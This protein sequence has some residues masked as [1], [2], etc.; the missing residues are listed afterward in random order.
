MLTAE[1]L[2]KRGIAGPSRCALFHVQEESSQY[3]FVECGYVKEAW[4]IVVEGLGNRFVWLNTYTCFFARWWKKYHGSF[5]QKDNMKCI[6]VVLPK[7]VCW[8][9]CLARNR[10]IFQEE[11]KNPK[12]RAIKALSLLS[13]HMCFRLKQSAQMLD[14]DEQR[15][16]SKFKLGNT[17]PLTKLRVLNSQNGRSGFPIMNSKNG[18]YSSSLIF[19]SSMGHL[20]TTWGW[21]EQGG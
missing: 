4:S 5:K 20:G 15:W 2:S 7:Y 8:C 16:I 13:E 18:S 10:A 14:V 19:F 3:L 1:N 12:R 11:K 21:Q 9:I 17:R 6:W